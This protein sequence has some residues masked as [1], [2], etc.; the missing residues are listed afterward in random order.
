MAYTY[1]H[2]FNLK[3]IGLRFFTV[4]GPWGR[5]DMALFKFVKNILNNQA[6]QVYNYGNLSRDFTY[7]DD[8]VDGIEKCIINLMRFNQADSGYYKIYN[9]GNNQPVKLKEFISVIENK[10][11]KKA[12][13]DF[14]DMQ[15]GDVLSTYAD[16]TEISKDLNYHPK[17]NINEGIEKFIS[18][19]RSYFNC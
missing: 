19:Y 12:I 11:D 10:L 8:I 3:T 9:I 16:I 5:P 13:L 6:I 15:P 18:W 4:Y 17:T 2:I 1:S 7:I 14:Q